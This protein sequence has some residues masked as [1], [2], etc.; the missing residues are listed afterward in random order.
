MSSDAERNSSRELAI[1]EA[2][3]KPIATPHDDSRRASSRVEAKDG[4]A[5]TV[6]NVSYAVEICDVSRDGAQIRM[7]QGLVPLVGQAVVL[8]FVNGTSV[9]CRV[10]WDQDTRIGLRFDEPLPDEMDGVYFDELGSD[11]FRAVL[12]LRILRG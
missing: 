6:H 7:R 9:N 3:S 11:Y 12:K 10:V 2:G 1:G 4:G 5:V 8:Q